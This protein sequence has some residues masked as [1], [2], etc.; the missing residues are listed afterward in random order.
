[1]TTTLLLAILIVA[2]LGATAIVLRRHRARPKPLTAHDK[3]LV[4]VKWHEIEQRLQKGGP[5]Q[6]RQAVIEADNLVDYVMKKL[7]IEGETMG[8]RLRSGQAWFSDYDGLWKAHKVRNQIVHELD[9]EVISFEAKQQI[10]RFRTALE[11][12][13]AL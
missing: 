5:T 9:K 12:L 6:F 10:K 7:S 1:M 4:H 2:A 13:G 8:E 11:D 3:S